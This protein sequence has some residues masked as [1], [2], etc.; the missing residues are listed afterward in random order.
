MWRSG[1]QIVLGQQAATQE[2]A[3][4]LGRVYK[5]RTR[6]VDSGRTNGSGRARR[7]AALLRSRPLRISLARALV[8]YRICGHRRRV[9]QRLDDRLEF[10]AG[11]FRDVGHDYIVSPHPLYWL[12]SSDFKD[13]IR[14][15]GECGIRTRA[16]RAVNT[17]C[18]AY[19]AGA[20]SH[21]ANSPQTRGAGSPAPFIL[22]TLERSIAKLVWP[23]QALILI[24]R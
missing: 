16:R 1:V 14:F 2:A 21:F 10:R 3:R 4:Y 5:V 20:I 13:T 12:Q 23:R 19:K 15:G 17:R 11:N 7:L 8:G 9:Q 22:R 6:G 18:A 24:L